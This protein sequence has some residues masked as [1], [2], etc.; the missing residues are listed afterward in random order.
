MTVSE[1][2]E[3]ITDYGLNYSSQKE[4]QCKLLNRESS[5]PVV[6]V[7]GDF[8]LPDI[9]WVDGSGV[10]KPNPTY[11]CELNNLFLDKINDNNLEQFAYKPT[12]NKN[13]L[14]LVFSSYPALVS[15]ISVIPRISD[16]NAVLFGFNTEG[17]IT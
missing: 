13:I 8:N 14:D 3:L 15:D 10:A 4:K 5:F 11:G 12:R 16:H 6:L 1:E 9:V 2:P 17:I 7:A